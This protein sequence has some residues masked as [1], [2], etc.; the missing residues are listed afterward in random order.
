[1]QQLNW[2]VASSRQRDTR[3]TPRFAQLDAILELL[4]VSKRRPG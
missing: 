1:M 3:M 2:S 4:D